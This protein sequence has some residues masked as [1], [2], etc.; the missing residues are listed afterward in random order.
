MRIAVDLD[1]T[2]FSCDCFLYK[3]ANKINTNSKDAKLKFCEI[4]K[5]EE[6]ELNFISRNVK[7][8]NHK[9]YQEMEDASFVMR[10]WN[11]LG[12]EIIILSSRPEWKMLRASVL[13]WL[14]NF[15]VDFTM[16]VVACNNKAEFCK[17]YNIDVLID[18]KF[19]VCKEAK[20][21]GVEVIWFC[22]DSVK[23]QTGK[24]K[25]AKDWNEVYQRVQEFEQKKI[26]ETFEEV[27]K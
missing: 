4:D 16:L 20:K 3:V 2:I 5:Y 24:I 10:K 22:G 8:F 11:E 26:T 19:S 9:Y 1:G 7:M 27:E 17:K 18:D 25:Q 15:S 21:N 12:Y 23:N 14:D 13:N 6:R